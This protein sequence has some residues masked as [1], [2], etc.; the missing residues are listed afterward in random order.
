MMMRL[1]DEIQQNRP[2]ASLE[3]EAFLSLGRSWAVL[4]HELAEMLR[5]HGLTPTQYNVL[6]ILRGAGETGLSRNEVIE[7]MISRVPDATRLLDR[8]EGNGLIRRERSLEDRRFVTTRIA[9]E[10]LRRLERLD[11]AVVA[12]HRNQF[13]G[14]EEDDLHTLI[15]L[16][17]RVRDRRQSAVQHGITGAGPAAL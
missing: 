14:M 2:F 13:A 5:G 12:L 4:D 7:R 1:K 10:G 16:L 8:L 11:D 17:E 6:R 3:Q 9:E 15:R